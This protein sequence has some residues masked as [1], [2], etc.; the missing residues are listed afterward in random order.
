MRNRI[1]RLAI[2]AAVPLAI[3]AA[4]VFAQAFTLPQ[5]LTSAPAY[6]VP[7]RL[8]AHRADLALTEPQAAELARLSADLHTQARLQAMSSKPWATA[9]RQASP[10]QAF[11][12][13]LK[14]LTPS[15]HAPAVRALA[16][17]EES[18]R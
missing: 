9:A 6:E 18:A 12:R 13:A 15:Q 8:L 5:P 4:A 1:F 11:D 2:S 17:T 3:P 14:T 10:R 16:A 7:D